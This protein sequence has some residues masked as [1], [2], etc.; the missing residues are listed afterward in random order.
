MDRCGTTVRRRALA[1]LSAALAMAPAS[2]QAGGIL[3]VTIAPSMRHAPSKLE[4][5]TP[6]VITFGRSMPIAGEPV[7]FSR[8]FY[9]S[10]TSAL[11]QRPITGSGFVP[12]SL[13]VAGRITSRFGM[14][15]HPLLGMYRFHAGVDL[16][17]PVGTAVIAPADGVVTLANWAGG[18]GL[19]VEL[20][21]GANAMRF[22]HLSRLN[23]TPGQQ[24]RQGD[25]LGY[26]GATGLATGAHLHYEVRQ[27]GRAV[28]PLGH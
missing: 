22:G 19:L 6:A 28:D 15:E 7:R 24:I 23:V 9:P 5:T 8:I 26:V 2:A 17:A 27:N 1:L 25:I 11:E 12:G 3:V 21:N 16:A 13:P 4:A 10:V 14:R 18:Y 20:E